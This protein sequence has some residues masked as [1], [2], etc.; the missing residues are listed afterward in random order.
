MLVVALVHSRLD[1]CNA[2]LVDIPAGTWYAVYSR[3]SMSCVR[4]TTSLMCWRHALQWLHIRERVTVQHTDAVLTYKLLQGSAPRYLG[5]LVAVAD[6]R[7]RRA[8]QSAS[9]SQLVVPLIK[10]STVD[11]SRAVIVAAGTVCQRPSSHR[12]HCRLSDVI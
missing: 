7:G 8:L 12:H 6:L 3:C 4:M 9:T 5:P 1:Y 2:V 11:G 10:L